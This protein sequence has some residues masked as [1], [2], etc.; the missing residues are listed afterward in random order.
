MDLRSRHLREHLLM[1][2]RHRQHVFGTV[3]SLLGHLHLSH[4]LRKHLFHQYQFLKI[5][6]DMNS[7]VQS[8]QKPYG[9]TTWTTTT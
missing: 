6:K 3:S 2:S 4:L 7:L 9:Q 8:F 5:I 1:G